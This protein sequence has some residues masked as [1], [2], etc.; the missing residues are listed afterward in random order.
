[1]IILSLYN[2]L[3]LAADLI[4]N[5][6][7]CTLYSIYILDILWLKRKALSEKKTISK[8]IENSGG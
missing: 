4:I 8:I 3:I 2:D 7:L 1:M 6:F 5:F